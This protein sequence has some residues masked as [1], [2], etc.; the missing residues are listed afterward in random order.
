MD[1]TDRINIAFGPRTT[2]ERFANESKEIREIHSDSL[3]PPSSLR[4]I[5]VRT[6][7]CLRI[8]H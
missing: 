5:K 2:A 7:D 6:L 1:A 3:N 4:L 8:G